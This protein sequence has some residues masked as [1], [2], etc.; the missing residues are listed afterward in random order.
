MR[1]GRAIDT[2]LAQMS[3]IGSD[4]LR[5][6]VSY[7][8]KDAAAADRL[9]ADLEARGFAVS[10]D[11]RDLPYGEEWQGELAGFIAACDA[12]VWLV[13]PSS[14][15]SD[16]CLWELGE[17]QRLAKKL[18]PVSVAETPPSRI[19]NWLRAR[20]MLP[21][22][23]VYTS[24][25]AD[26]LAR[27]L[28]TDHAWVKEHTRIGLLA[29]RWDS[30][31]RPDWELL[32]GNSL[33]GAEKWLMQAPRAAP[34]P[35]ELHRAYIAASREAEIV[36]QA[37]AEARRER[38]LEQARALAEEQRARADTE[39]R[40]R[41]D[42][43]SRQ[44]AAQSQALGEGQ[45]DLALVLAIEANRVAA[46]QEAQNALLQHVAAHPHLVSFLSGINVDVPVGAKRFRLQGVAFASDGRTLAHIESLRRARLKVWTF[47]PDLEFVA[48]L[49]A[50]RASLAAL[51]FTPDGSRLAA[52][53]EAGVV[54]LW[55]RE[56]WRGV[57]SADLSAAD[58]E[59]GALSGACIA[60]S[61]DGRRLAAGC[62]QFIVLVDAESGRVEQRI[63]L[64]QVRVVQR[65]F[66]ARSGGALIG[67]GFAAEGDLNADVAVIIDL[68]T[69]AE[70][71][72]PATVADLSRD[73]REARCMN[74]KERRL[75]RLDVDARTISAGIALPQRDYSGAWSVSRDE[76]WL[77]VAE[78]DQFHLEPL[79]QQ[80]GKRQ[81]RLVGHH[82]SAYIDGI[83]FSPDGGMFASI[84]FDDAT[85]LWKTTGRHRLSRSLARRIP[86]ADDAFASLALSF[87][88]DS[89]HLANLS[90]DGRL[91]VTR[92]SDGEALPLPAERFTHIDRYGGGW[93][94]LTA[95]NRLCVI[96][97]AGT[98]AIR[99]L[100]ALEVR[101][102]AIAFAA[103]A[104]V[105]VLVDEER[106][107]YRVQLLPFA[108][109]LVGA[110]MLDAASDAGTDAGWAGRRLAISPDGTWA[111]IGLEDDFAELVPLADGSGQPRRLE[112]GLW[113]N[114][115]AFAH[116]GRMLLVTGSESF[117]LW[118]VD[119]GAP[120]IQFSTGSG[121]GAPAIADVSPD[122]AFLAWATLHDQHVK[123][124]DGLG[125]QRI[126]SLP[127]L[128]GKRLQ[129]SLAFS[130][131]GRLL[132]VDDGAGGAELWTFERDAWIE[133]AR[134]MAN[135]T[136]R[137]DERRRFLP[138]EEAE[139]ER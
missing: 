53:D 119:T 109:T 139:E 86:V 43:T 65:V 80:A 76:R 62:D 23:G 131:D 49:E 50:G 56:A 93:L 1:Q 11:R 59:G 104:G 18:I 34:E 135:R 67:Q 79:D 14:V 19:P 100:P 110:T 127:P 12:V 115:V 46:T 91:L 72:L 8:R 114:R 120:V 27:V 134:A 108:V 97:P 51:D 29:T 88:A 95:D 40:R 130:P 77:A 15:V 113:R 75:D 133:F 55:A 90:D 68:A 138:D 7:S 111:A 85:I 16:W 124:H 41:T 117:Q 107:L 87:T 31:H 105:G 25:L 44:L 116:S 83:T 54:W 36:E 22:E 137:P 126:C 78:S 24:A 82:R 125:T 6:F 71:R 128:E 60:F 48:E 30:Q 63:A 28:E 20:Q 84:A 58:A 129:A 42:A 118:D 26:T 81:D 4:A 57:W 35:T 74:P 37:A 112:T 123:V 94:G 9:V 17:V 13:T 103:T 61:P 47:E 39:R 96:E 122:G 3:N 132:A 10:I 2:A 101:A 106:R 102:A 33:L 32:R 136:L 5:V 98:L 121:I 38:E 89:G 92:T 70:D 52:L 73:G 69:L 99:F 45:L 64:A 21:A 66:W